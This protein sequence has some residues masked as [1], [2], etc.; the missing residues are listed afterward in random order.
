MP[1]ITA[2]SLAGSDVEMGRYKTYFDSGL[3]GRTRNIRVASEAVNGIVLMPGELLSFNQL[4]GERTWDK[5]YRMAH[6][7]ETKPGK[8]EAGSCGWAGWRRVSGV[9]H[10]I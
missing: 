8:S 2:A 7:F 3:W 5:G 10:I 6:I 4:T 1:R 9:K